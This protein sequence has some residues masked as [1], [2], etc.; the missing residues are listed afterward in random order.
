MECRSG[1]HPSKNERTDDRV[2]TRSYFPKRKHQD[3]RLAIPRYCGKIS[4]DCFEPVYINRWYLPFFQLCI[5]RERRDVHLSAD[6]PKVPRQ[7]QTP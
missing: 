1:S 3:E 2:T 4:G 5:Y 6:G 7:C